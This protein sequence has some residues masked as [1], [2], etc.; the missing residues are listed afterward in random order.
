MERFNSEEARKIWRMWNYRGVKLNDIAFCM[1]CSVQEVR[2]A[3][4]RI[5]REEEQR[6]LIEAIGS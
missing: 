6:G 4:R 5:D 1:K 3:I 2:E